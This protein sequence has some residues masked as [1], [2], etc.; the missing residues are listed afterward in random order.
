MEWLDR[1]TSV[2]DSVSD[3]ASD[4]IGITDM[5]RKTGLSK[6]TLHRMVQ[7]MVSHDLLIQVAATKKYRLGPRSLV[8]GSNFVIGQDP[9]NLLSGSCDLLAESTNLYVFLCRFERGDVYCIYTRQPQNGQK[10]YFV[11]VGQR[12]P[13]HCTAAA[14][15][16]LAFLPPVEVEKWFARHTLPPFTA[17]T[18]TVLQDV[19]AE[20]PAIQQT[21]VAFCWE[22][23]EIGVSAISTPVFADKG[24]PAFSI[25]LIGESAHIKKNQHV[26]MEE[27]VQAGV[28]ASKHMQMAYALTSAKG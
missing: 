22:E 13:L 14:K 16:I 11:H 24:Q 25:S 18:K 23:L 5:M 12:M 4:G 1:F 3:A 26:L 28:K 7:D 10:K 8:W 20:F 2:M 19:M 27:I 21:K 17:R 15:A 6:G 9:A